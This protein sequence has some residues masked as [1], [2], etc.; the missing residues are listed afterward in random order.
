META[1]FFVKVLGSMF[2]RPDMQ[3]TNKS[4]WEDSK[5]KRSNI[6]GGAFC[7][8][9]LNNVK[10]TFQSIIKKVKIYGP[11]NVKI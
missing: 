9:I 6:L 5:K 7:S 1:C 3:D 10:L 8:T 4:E 11:T 2:S